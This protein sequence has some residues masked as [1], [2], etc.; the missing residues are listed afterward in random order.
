M[1]QGCLFS[2]FSEGITT[3]VYP[4]GDPS[5]LAPTPRQSHALK[6]LGTG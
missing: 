3:V 2:L 4:F 5:R 6:S 1:D